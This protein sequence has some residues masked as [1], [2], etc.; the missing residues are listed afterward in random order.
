MLE[1]STD[2][3]RAADDAAVG[4]E[5]LGLA[6]LG[7]WLAGAMRRRGSSTPELGFLP[8]DRPTE[9]IVEPHARFRCW[10]SGGGDIRDC[11]RFRRRL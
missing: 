9:V 11:C 6:E 1:T 10:R 3:A 2:C 8:D 7:L 4:R 5:E